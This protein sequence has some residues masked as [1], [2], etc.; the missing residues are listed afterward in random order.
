MKITKFEK[1][2]LKVHSQEEVGDIVCGVLSVFISIVQLVL[3]GFH[4]LLLPIMVQV[5]MSL[6]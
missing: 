5:T 4:L 2:G 3:Q 6:F 1:D